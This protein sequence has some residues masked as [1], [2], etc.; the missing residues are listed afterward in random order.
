MTKL[1]KNDSET[2]MKTIA[3]YMTLFFFMSS[4]A[5]ATSFQCWDGSNVSD[6]APLC[7]AKP[8][9]LNTNITVDCSGFAG[10]TEVTEFWTDKAH[11]TCG[12]PDMD[13]VLHISS[14]TMKL[15]PPD[16]FDHIYDGVQ[17]AGLSCLTFQLSD[18]TGGF[19]YLAPDGRARISNYPYDNRCQPFRN[20]V[21][22][23]Y[24][25]GKAV[26][27]DTNLDVVRQTNYELANPFYKH[28][29]KVCLI[30]PEKIYQGEKF[31]WVGGQCGFI[32]TD[33][34]E[35]V[36]ILTPYEDTHRLTGG[37]YDGVELDRWDRPVLELLAAHID[38]STEQIEAVFRP[39]GCQLK[40][41]SD[42]ET[43]GLNIPTD[44]DEDKTWLKIM[45]F[46]L[47]DQRLWEGH[48]F[49][50]RQHNLKLH[51]LKPI[52]RLPEK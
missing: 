46:R 38:V 48:V 42:A 39:S 11:K 43:A 47:E 32:D 15:I 37:K 20:G 27:F 17:T 50:D 49:S 28:L 24:V 13:G 35:V 25:R 34:N 36:P 6:E 5:A 8:T 52:D 33:F 19:G 16:H 31:K 51:S 22:I 12:H 1:E 41:C 45:R 9:K 7:P 2:S 10:W 30:S 3:R 18:S 14:Q 26:F 21:A 23:S 40:Y 29:A 44:L 4:P